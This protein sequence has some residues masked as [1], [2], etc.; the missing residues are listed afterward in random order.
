MVHL[1]CRK[2]C[3]QSR[4]V[5]LVLE[6]GNVIDCI[7]VASPGFSSDAQ[8]FTCLV[9]AAL[10]LTDHPY[11]AVRSDTRVIEEVNDWRIQNAQIFHES[12]SFLFPTSASAPVR[13]PFSSTASGN[14][15]LPPV[16]A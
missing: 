16:D 12:I 9:I 1:L 11:Q 7:T 14:P 3:L 6:T 10:L 2:L 5:H 13:K 8:S 4:V 15:I